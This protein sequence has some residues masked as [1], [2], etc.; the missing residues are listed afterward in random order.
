L[1]KR[2]E[3]TVGKI[4]VGS[5]SPIKLEASGDAVREIGL[6]IA[7]AA[8]ESFSNVNVQPEGYGE[9]MKGAQVRAEFA[10]A[11]HADE[12]TLAA[13]GIENGVVRKQGRYY[14][15]AAIQL[16]RPS[17]LSLIAWSK[18]FPLP[19]MFVTEAWKR[20]FH[21]TTVGRVIAEYAAVWGAEC[22]HH[23]PH[24]FLTGGEVTRKMILTEAIIR[25]F[26]NPMLASWIK[27]IRG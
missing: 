6:P 9:I 19:E 13:L 16:V 12:D 22:D 10:F 3:L 21:R 17:G 7:V 26:V 27:T 11:T 1:K 24:A 4:L 8:V 2:K 23:D 18:P 15:I 5:W 20:G 25:L 14:D